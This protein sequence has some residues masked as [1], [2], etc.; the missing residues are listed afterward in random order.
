MFQTNTIHVHNETL[1]TPKRRRITPEFTS[2]LIPRTPEPPRMLNPDGSIMTWGDTAVK[3]TNRWYTIHEIDMIVNN[4]WKKRGSFMEPPKL[5]RIKKA[6]II[7]KASRQ[8][9]STFFTNYV[10][11]ELQQNQED[12]QMDFSTEE[13]DRLNRILDYDECEINNHFV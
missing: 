5:E 4:L 13:I 3:M 10:A 9:P 2:G 11:D 7:D 8:M 12:A 6:A 1:R